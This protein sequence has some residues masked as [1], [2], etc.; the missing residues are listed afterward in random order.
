[1]KGGAIMKLIF[2][3]YNIILW[4]SILLTGFSL[5]LLSEIRDVYAADED[6]PCPVP[7]VDTLLPRAGTPGEKIKIWGN[8]FGKEQGSVTFSPGVKSPILK[9]T[10][11]RIWITVPEIAETGPVAVSAFCGELSNKIHFTIKDEA[12]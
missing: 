10:N 4:S 3:K 7:Y 9:W 8:R 6:K 1:M 12:E 11:K 5:Y 2:H